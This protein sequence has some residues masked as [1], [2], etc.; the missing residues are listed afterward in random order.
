MPVVSQKDGAKLIPSISR[1]NNS[2]ATT[3]SEK[4]PKPAGKFTMHEKSHKP[5]FDPQELEPLLIARAN[6]GDIDGM[7]AL[8]EPNA[9][10]AIGGGK[11]A[12]GAAEI[13][14]F[15][16]YLLA[17]G[18][19]FHAGEQYPA[20]CN[21]DLALTSSRYHNGTFSSEVAR[22]QEDGA[23]LWVIDYPTMGE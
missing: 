13:R 6:A 1:N 12:R 3:N 7:V 11:V 16:A 19:V 8:F 23:W 9:V 2:A 17:S 21:G 4:A 10:V 14:E 5:V 20:I 18:F 22:R 15:Y